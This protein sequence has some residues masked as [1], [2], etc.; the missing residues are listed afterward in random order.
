ML[1]VAGEELLIVFRGGFG[2][3]GDFLGVKAIAQE[4][5]ERWFGGVGGKQ[6][7]RGG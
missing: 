3:A 4:F 2:I 5:A 1:G 6:C 7:A